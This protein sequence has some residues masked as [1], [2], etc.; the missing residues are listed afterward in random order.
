MDDADKTGLNPEQ[1]VFYIRHFVFHP[2]VCLKR[3]SV[4]LKTHVYLS[5]LYARSLIHL[6]NIVGMTPASYPTQKLN[7]TCRQ[8][9]TKRTYVC[10]DAK[11]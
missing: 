9:P 11:Y 7:T 2:S 4:C 5:A 10:L 3:T 6:I 1:S 8:K